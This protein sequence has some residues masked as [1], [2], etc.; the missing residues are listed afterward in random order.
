MR[1]PTVLRLIHEIHRRSLWQVVGIYLVGSWIG[2]QVILA[3]TDGLGLPSWVPPFA[4]VLFII[5]LPL[6][7]ATAFVQEGAP[8]VAGPVPREDAFPD[9]ALEPHLL[10]GDVFA[11]GGEAGGRERPGTGGPGA[12]RG[13]LTWRRAVLAGVVAFALL[14]A[15]TA[16]WV[17]LR[18]LGV[19]PAGSLVAAGA[20]EAHQRILVADFQSPSRD[21]V[22]A[23]V[24]TEAFRIDFSRSTLVRTVDPGAVRDVL[25]RMGR[26]GEP[27]LTPELAQEVALRDGISAYIVGDLAAAGAGFVITA[28]LVGTETGQTLVALRETA[29]DSAD[30]VPAI[31]R[32]SRALRER[33][34]ESLRTV[35]RTPPLEQVTT[36]SLE[37]LRKYTDGRRAQVWQADQAR[38]LELY[39]EAVALDTAFASAWRSIATVHYNRDD[40]EPALEAVERALRFQDRLTEMERHLAT[41]LH[42]ATL[43]DHGRAVAAYERALTIDPHDATALNNLGMMYNQLDDLPRAERYFRRALA[44]D[45]TRLTQRSNLASVLVRLGRLDDARAEYERGVELDPDAQGARVALATLPAVAGDYAA[46]ERDLRAMMDDHA[47]PRRATQQAAQRIFALLLVQGR[48]AEALRLAEEAGRTAD[49]PETFGRIRDLTL[50]WIDAEVLGRPERARA[51]LARIRPLHER[52]AEA[53]STQM[54]PLALACLML[55]DAACAR[56]YMTRAGVA[57]RLEPWSPRWQYDL[58]AWLARVEGD[59]PAALRL[60]RAS[61]ESWCWKCFEIGVARTFLDAGMPDSASAAYERFLAS[62]SIGRAVSADRELALIHARL[63][64]QY[65]SRGDRR[66]AALHHARVIEVWERADPELQPIVEQARRALARLRA[67]AGA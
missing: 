62:S 22:L 4:F 34:G 19:G 66:S 50:I 42:S 29:R 11:G 15:G 56:E 8:R 7:V 58:H 12:L 6:V 9:T 51:T 43:L 33:T 36:S 64:D 49:N 40:P 3:L 41:A 14:G 63:A 1:R 65:E 44:A 25:R 17:G 20:L 46:A 67:D 54:V 24:V 18:A 61:A 16:A 21:S 32:L 10:R 13:L 2:Y 38:G 45:T 48:L 57:G 37:A 5:G 60:Y 27:A 31:D 47:L 26:S 23:A 52:W 55:N 39:Q 35:R 59:F 28:R 30:I 53:D